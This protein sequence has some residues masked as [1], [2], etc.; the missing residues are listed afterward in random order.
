MKVGE[1]GIGTV[2]RLVGYSFINRGDD[3][4]FVTEHD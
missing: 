1:H 2:V 3:S 4:R